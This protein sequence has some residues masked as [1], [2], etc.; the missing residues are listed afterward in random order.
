MSD[1]EVVGGEWWWRGH[2]VV[3]TT[4]LWFQKNNFFV[5]LRKKYGRKT[6]NGVFLD[7]GSI[8][9]RLWDRESDGSS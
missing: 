5:W 3:N 6:K 4:W 2:W 1:D 9:D 8:H 7:H